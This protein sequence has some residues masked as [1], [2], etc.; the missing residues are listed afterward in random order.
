MISTTNPH[1]IGYDEPSI[2]IPLSPYILLF[3]YNDHGDGEYK[4]GR[5]DHEVGDK[6]KDD[7]GGDG[8]GDIGGDDDDSGMRM[9]SGVRLPFMST[10]D[11]V[12]NPIYFPV[13][14][15]V[16]SSPMFGR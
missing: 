15:V 14:R 2:L 16:F 8:H 7:G 12:P 11:Y 13:S 5:H 1:R 6:E 10:S 4:D 3:S 9:V